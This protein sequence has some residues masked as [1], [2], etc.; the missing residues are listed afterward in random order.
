MHCVVVL[1]PASGTGDHAS[2]VERLADEHGCQVAVSTEPGHAVELAADAVRDGADTVLAAGGD[3]T[4]NEV[5]RGIHRT[6]GFDDIVLGVVPVGTGNNFAQNIGVTGLRGAFRLLERGERRWIDLGIADVNGMTHPFINSCIGGLAAAASDQ[7]SAAMKRRFGSLAYVLTTVRLA[8]AAAETRLHVQ[9]DDRNW[10]GDAR[11]VLV[12]NGRRYPANGTQ[13]DMEDG[14]FDVTIIEEESL[15]EL[16]GE[17]AVQ[18]LLGGDTPAITHLHAAAVTVTTD[19]GERP[20]SLDGEIVHGRRVRLTVRPQR[21]Q[22]IVGDRYR[23][24]PD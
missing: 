8:S 7:T 23:P 9:S 21:V 12:G 3:G 14:R 6:D 22:L 5:V 15:P 10:S 1:N 16:A 24:H 20:F 18:Q 11:I 4:V 2:R 19:G 17:T 13:A